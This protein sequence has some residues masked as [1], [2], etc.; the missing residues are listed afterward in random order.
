[1]KEEV[2]A[3][4]VPIQKYSG[5]EKLTSTKTTLNACSL[6]SDRFQQSWDYEKLCIRRVFVG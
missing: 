5:A 6:A 3:K 1:M 2:C 4:H